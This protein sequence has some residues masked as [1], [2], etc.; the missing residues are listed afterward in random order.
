MTINQFSQE[1]EYLIRARYSVIYVNSPEEERALD[2]ISGICRKLNK[3][4]IT[5]TATR[6]LELNNSCLDNKSLDFKTAISMAE[7]LAKEPTIFI[8]LDVHGYFKNT[9]S[10]INTRRF[11]EF[12]QNIRKGLPSNS[13]I[14]STVIEIPVELQKEVAILDLPLPT[15]DQAKTIISNFLTSFRNNPTLVLDQSPETLDVLG[16]A[17]L[18][19]TQAE[20]ENSLAKALVQYQKITSDQVESILDEKKQIIRKS[21]ILEYI[22]TESLELEDIGGLQNLKR[23]LDKRKGA[24][25]MEAQD[26]GIQWP[27]GVMVVGVPGCGKSLSAKCVA[28]AWKMPLIR[29]DLGRVFSGIVGSSEANMRI[30]LSTCEAL[31]PCIVWIDEIE[32]ALSGI[33]SSS[34]GGTATRIFGTL[35]TWMQEKNSPVFVFATAN[36]IDSLPPELLRKGRFDET[37]FV[38]LPNETERKEIFKIHIKKL[39]RNI[40]G[41]NLDELTNHSGEMHWGEGVRLTGSEIEAAVKEGLLESYYRKKSIDS[42]TDLT[43]EDIIQAMSRMVP[44]AKVKQSEITQLKNWA[45]QNAVRASLV[46]HDIQNNIQEINVGRNIDF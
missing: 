31:A 1:L 43:T 44:L 35:L 25:S 29:L 9:S 11:K 38:D 2:L 5:W 4:I 20:I 24:F 32:K 28:S 16:R 37:F 21:G 33:G 22:S 39:K 3:R 6:G 30:A 18:G 14:I 40:N 45:N 17:A 23:W 36:N 10:I 27:K 15:L 26:Y 19:L 7:E 46:N 8:W 42:G 12:S 41:F 13:I 34:D